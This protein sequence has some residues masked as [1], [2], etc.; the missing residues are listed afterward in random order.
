MVEYI[1]ICSEYKDGSLLKIGYF[2]ANALVVDED[3]LNPFAIFPA[4]LINFLVGPGVLAV[5]MLL[6]IFKLPLV[7]A[8]V[9]PLHY[10]SAVH[11]NK[12]RLT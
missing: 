10:P 6:P 7:D 9:A 3:A 12:L 5:P 11:L 4:A 1:L 2:F 8:A